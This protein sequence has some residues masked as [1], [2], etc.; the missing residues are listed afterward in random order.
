MDK[1][2]A[3]FLMGV[4][5]GMV[6]LGNIWSAYGT[7]WNA[8][9]IAKCYEKQEWCAEEMPRLFDALSHTHP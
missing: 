9:S 4:V 7:K 1:V 5:I 2:K 6:L 3:W 8:K